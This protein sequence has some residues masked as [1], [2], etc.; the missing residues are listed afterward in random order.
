MHPG[1]PAVP[2]LGAHG[3]R[4]P[5]RPGRAAEE[6]LRHLPG[7]A[8]ARASPDD[9]VHQ[10][11]QD[12]GLVSAILIWRLDKGYIDAA[13]VSYLEGDG[14]TLEGQAR[15]GHR[16][17]TRCSPAPAAATRTRP[18]RSPTTRPLERGFSNAGARRHELPV[19]GAAGDVEPQDRQGRQ[20]DRASTSACCARRPSTTRIFEEL[21]D[22]KYGMAK[23][24]IIEDEHQ[25]RLPDLDAR[26]RA[27]TRSTSRSATPG[28]ARAATTA[29]TSP[30]S[31]PTSRRAA[32]ASSTTGRSPS[33]APSSAGRS[34]AG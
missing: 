32:S 33:S 27:T 34:S 20:A 6:A 12:G 25:G 29:L 22:A 26:R 15:R 5:L 21:F 17:R 4:A 3:R 2:R 24:E 23:R 10:I 28:P 1:L 8:P 31:T 30:P 14:S 13:L 16:P 7:R 9:M 18:T 19:V 11:G